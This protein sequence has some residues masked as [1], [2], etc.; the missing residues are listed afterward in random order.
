MKKLLTIAAMAGVA[1]LSYGQGYVNFTSQVGATAATNSVASANGGSGPTGV[2]VKNATN[3]VYYYAL[4][5]APST[6]QT[7]GATVIGDPTSSGWTFTGDY[8]TNGNKSAFNG[9]GTTDTSSVQVPGFGAGTTAD[10]MI[11]GW[12]GNIGSTWA[13]AEAVI[14]GG[15]AAPAAAAGTAFFSIGDSLVGQQVLALGVVLTTI[16]WAHRP[17]FRASS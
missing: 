6:A 16:S 15:Y 12:S 17:R 2:T 1:S 4:F 11:V 5:V 8:A 9:W 7:V 10:F 13:A 3:S 14:D